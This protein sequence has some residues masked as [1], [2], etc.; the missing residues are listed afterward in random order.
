M[1]DLRAAITDALGPMYRVEREVRPIGEHRLFVVT[2]IAGPELL[3]KVLPAAISLSIDAQKFERDVLLAA[4]K[5]RH[6]SLVAPKGGGR[7]GSFIYHTRPFI[8]GTTLHAWMAR[9]GSVPLARAIEI[10]R[11]VLSGLAHAHAGGIAHGDLRAEHVL[12]AADQALVADMGIA[13]ILGHVATAR[14]DMDAFGALILEMLA[15]PV[16]RA[17]EEALDRSRTLPAWLTEWMQTRWIDAGKA[18]A[19]LRLP[20][21]PPPFNNRA[22]QPVV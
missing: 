12:L 3:V 14:K 20:P 16:D 15:I 11:G 17:S 2:Q 8:A 4:E 1:S 7:A 9:N 13:R 21:Q 10:M 22:T 18:L 5:L 19:A 6:P